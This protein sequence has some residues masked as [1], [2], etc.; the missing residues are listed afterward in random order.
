M[1]KIQE[2]VIKQYP[3][4]FGQGVR[5]VKAVG[6]MYEIMSEGGETVYLTR[7]FADKL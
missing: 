5:Y 6:H 7:E 3:S 4:R 1:N 2:Y